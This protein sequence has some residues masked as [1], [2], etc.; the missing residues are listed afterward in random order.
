MLNES[1]LYREL[2]AHYLKCVNPNSPPTPFEAEKELLDL[3]YAAIETENKSRPNGAKIKYPKSLPN[4]VIADVIKALH[5]VCR[6]AFSSVDPHINN[7]LCIYMAEGEK[8]GTYARDEEFIKS[9]IKSYN[10]NASSHD[11]SEVLSILS[12]SA[13]IKEPCRE[14]DLIAVNNGVFNYKTKIL[15]DFDPSFVFLSKSP[16]NYNPKAA[17]VSILNDDGTLWSVNGWMN[18]LSDD[19]TVVSLLWEIIGSVLRNNVRWNKCIMLYGANGCGGKSTIMQVM[20]SL[21]GKNSVAT[22]PF[23]SFGKDFMLEQVLHCKAILT[24]EVPNRQFLQTPDTFKTLLTG[25]PVELTRKFKVNITAELNIVIVMALNALVTFADKSESLTR[26]LLFVPMTKCFTGHENKRIK[27]EY[28]HRDDVLEYFLY[29]V[30][31]SNYYSFSEPEPCRALLE[32]FKENNNTIR[33]YLNTVLPLWKNRLAP[34]SLLYDLYRAWLKKNCPSTVA[35]KS[36]LFNDEVRDI[37]SEYPDWDAPDHPIPTRQNL[38]I[39]EPLI[40]DY[41]LIDWQSSE[42]GSSRYHIKINSSSYRGIIRCT[43]P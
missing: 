17:D 11:K 7:N 43:T 38:S 10:Y 9:L 16:V 33:E 36:S 12:S 28:L 27:S 1:T 8:R 35:I 13:P 24:D 15:K 23:A 14:P 39:G 6:V 34:Y 22:V 20:R 25:D 31:H 30:L 4:S 32:L 19:S 26:R 21:C 29:R 3:F 37:I 5:P 41:N 42:M 2:T 18:S 40:V